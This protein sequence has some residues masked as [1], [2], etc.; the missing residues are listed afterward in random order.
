QKPQRRDYRMS[1]PEYMTMTEALKGLRS[2]GFITNFAFLHDAFCAV[3][4][5]K[6]FK[7]EELSI[8]EH[9]RFEG[10]SDPDDESVVYAVE[11]H[12]GLRGTIVDA[13]GIYANSELE[14]FLEKVD[15][16]EER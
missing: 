8:R 13:Y 14:A 6:T 1:H 9:H 5:G 15:M 2:R 11:T 3:E 16:Q 10:I 4:S 12:D 7:P